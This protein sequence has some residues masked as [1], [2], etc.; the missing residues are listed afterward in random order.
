MK[1]FTPA[2][3]VF[4]LTIS[5]ENSFAQGTESYCKIA[6]HLVELINAADYSGASDSASCS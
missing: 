1:Q 6:H 5:P 4:A 3:L 2:V